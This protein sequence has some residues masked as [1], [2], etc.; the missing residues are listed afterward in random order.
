MATFSAK[1]L[2]AI[3][4][5]DLRTFTA[6]RLETGAA[7]A[8]IKRE[9]AIVKRAFRLAGEDDKYHGRVPKIPMLQKR[10]VR[11]GFFDDE[12]VAAVLTH[13]PAA[14]RSVVQFAYVTRA[15]RDSSA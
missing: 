7:N 12:M 14:L 5:A 2:S 13:L 10:T 1:K 11:T 6:R 4:T 15:K 8:E 9:L 3:R